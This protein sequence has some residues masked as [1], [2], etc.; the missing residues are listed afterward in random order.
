MLSFIQVVELYAVNN[1]GLYI[2]PA[3]LFVLRQP[4]VVLHFQLSVSALCRYPF[5]LVSLSLFPVL[6]QGGLFDENYF[7]R[8]P[9]HTTHS[10]FV[11]SYLP[12]G[13]RVIILLLNTYLLVC[14]RTVVVALVPHIVIKILVILSQI[15]WK[16]FRY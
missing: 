3:R 10:M 13:C 16:T 6:S 12:A 8:P 14:Y 7:T 15:C 11:I 9:K 2:I 5:S 4:F 1:R